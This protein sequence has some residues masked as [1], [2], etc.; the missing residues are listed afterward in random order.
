MAGNGFVESQLVFFALIAV[1]VLLAWVY[2]LYGS[3][4]VYLHVSYFR[5]VDV[6]NCKIFR[7]DAMDAMFSSIVMSW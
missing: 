6:V 7:R 1:F 3:Y 5:I 4:M 2:Q